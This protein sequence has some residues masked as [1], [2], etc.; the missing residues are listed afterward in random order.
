MHGHQSS[1]GP[2]THGVGG[3]AL[4]PTRCQRAT[5]APEPCSCAQKDQWH[6][7]QKRE[8]LS[9]QARARGAGQGPLSG[10]CKVKSE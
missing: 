4:G 9:W 6:P 1:S 5:K 10:R 7:R 2:L 3:A 8:G